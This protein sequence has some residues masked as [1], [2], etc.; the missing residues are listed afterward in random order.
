MLVNVFS[1]TTPPRV[2]PRV[3]SIV[4][5]ALSLSFMAAIVALAR[6]FKSIAW[7]Q[8]AVGA[9]W[10][11]TLAYGHH[12][13]CWPPHGYAA[14]REAAFAKAGGGSSCGKDDAAAH[15][16]PTR[17]KVADVSVSVCPRPTPPLT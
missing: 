1:N 17:C 8:P 5:L 15:R 10:L 14:P 9:P 12:E 7:P 13:D 11:W 3:V 6:D 4:G 2:K 16:A